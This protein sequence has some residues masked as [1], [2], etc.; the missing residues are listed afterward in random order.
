MNQTPSV[1]LLVVCACTFGCDQKKSAPA[2][3]TAAPA[4]TVAAPSPAPPR[5]ASALGKMSEPPDNPTTAA[6][7]ELGRQ[8]FFD[9]RMSSDGAL[10]CYS[11][12]RNEDGTGG[13]DPVAT[14]AGG[15][16]LTRHAPTMWNVGYLPLLYWDGRS[17]SLEAQMKAAWTGGNMGVGEEGLSA[18]VDEIAKVE[19]YRKQFADIWP[20]KGVTATTIAMAVSAYERTLVCDDTAWDRFNAGDGAALSEEQKQGWALFTGKA[21]CNEC[22]TPPMFSDAYA[23][24]DGAFHNVGIGTPGKKKDEVDPGRMKVTN[25]SAD[26]SQWKTP[27]LRN[28]SKSAPYFHDGSVAKLEDA[29]KLMAGG[30][31]A[32]EN[33]D[34]KLKDRGLTGAELAQLVAFLG[35]LECGGK[36]E[37]PELP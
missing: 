11:C 13:H 30:G 15:K 29:V 12:H 33:L 6:K 27:S 16:K 34:P 31:H 20:G 28:V 7:V 3:G 9:P 23:S 21:L 35:A 2:P 37:K 10:S 17:D 14:G 4:A 5:K 18:K 32:N 22:H 26:W 19:A 36:L 8:L 25:N 24:K 1:A